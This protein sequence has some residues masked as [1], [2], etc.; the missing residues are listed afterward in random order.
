MTEQSSQKAPKVFISHATAD[1]DRFVLP[2][3]TRLRSKGVDAWVDQWEMLPGDSL[4]NK[5]F[6]EGLKNCETFVVVL[7]KN[8]IEK[9]WVREELNAAM[10]KK[11]EEGRKLIPIRLDGCEIPECL[12]HTLWQDIH[13]LDNYD[14]SFERVLNSILGVYDKPPL[15]DRPA[16]ARPGPE[17]VPGVAPIDGLVFAQACRLAIAN[18]L[19]IIP[20]EAICVP[21]AEQ[22]ISRDQ[23]GES[24]EILA[25]RHYIDPLKGVKPMPGFKITSFGF[26]NFLRSE[27]PEFDATLARISVLLATNT[28]D[29]TERLA[30]TLDLPLRTTAYFLDLLHA[31]G[32]IKAAPSVPAV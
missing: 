1:K 16:Y 10:I 17:T 22:G 3:A 29:N 5:I 8:S 7:S 24:L 20:T 32:L 21:L 4:V 23:V 2:F 12:K 26:G 13:D 14:Q 6:D 25:H 9:A 28:A 30:T 19:Y 31:K 27:L 11:I 18:D 15:G